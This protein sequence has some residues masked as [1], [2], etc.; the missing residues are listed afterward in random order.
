MY[1]YPDKY[2]GKPNEYLLDDKRG[3]APT[4][5]VH[6]YLNEMRLQP[7]DLPQFPS[8]VKINFNE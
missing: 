4:T 3:I 6:K 5:N 1:G 8:E 2:M 7:S